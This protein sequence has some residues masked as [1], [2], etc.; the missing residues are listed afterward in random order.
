[1]LP[2]K[3][4]TLRYETAKD[5]VPD[6]S[7]YSAFDGSSVFE[8]QRLFAEVAVVFVDPVLA[9]WS[10][11]VEVDAIFLGGCGVGEI[12][13]DDEDF[14][15]VDGV[16]GAVVEVEAESAFG[17]EGDLLVGMGV[18]GNDAAFGENDA[19]KHRLRAGDEL[20]G[21][22]RVELLIFDVV[23]AIKSGFGHGGSA[24]LWGD[25]GGR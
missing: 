12:A 11:D 14:A 5:G 9:G 24:F 13:G 18:A 23:P 25:G 6:F 16:R 8:V 4:P 3:Y 1:V 2:H 15:S 21:E 20:A 19:G 17:D 10:E 22:E 7:E